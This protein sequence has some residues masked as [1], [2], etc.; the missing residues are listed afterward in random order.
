[1]RTI[2]R[3]EIAVPAVDEGDD[4]DGRQDRAGQRQRYV[5]EVAEVAAPI[6]HR[7]V[8]QLGR[9]LP[10]RVAQKKNAHRQREGDLRQDD[11][12]IGVEKAEVADL[13]EQRQ[14]RGRQRKQ[15]PELQIAQEKAVAE[16]LA[17]ARR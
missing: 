6:H 8:E 15:K 5:E 12:P 16:E 10:E 2:E 4:R 1:M 9:Q 11:A 7:R 3:Q 14:D 13:D 17:D